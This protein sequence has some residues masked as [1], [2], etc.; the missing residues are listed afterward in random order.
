MS[1][2]QTA[3]GVGLAPCDT[4]VCGGFPSSSCSLNLSSA[5][6]IDQEDAETLEVP[7]PPVKR[8]S[9]QGSCSRLITMILNVGV[10]VFKRVCPM[11]ISGGRKM[12]HQ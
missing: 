8:S 1:G 12:A 11:R 2:A 7:A 4:S 10:S 9:V 5:R 3:L 6:S